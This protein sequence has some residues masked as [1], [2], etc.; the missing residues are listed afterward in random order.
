MIYQFQDVDTGEPVELSYS[1]SEVP[2]IGE[3]VEKNGKKFKR[4]FSDC[5][6]DAGIESKVHGYPYVSSSLPR[7]LAGCETNN[8]GK[9]IITSRKH[10][11]EVMN[12]HGYSRD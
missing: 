9:P 6:V 11:K 12:Q 10:E 1:M 2:S 4:V 8:Q 3:I 7:N 5:F